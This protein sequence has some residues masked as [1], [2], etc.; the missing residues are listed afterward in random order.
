MRSHSVKQLMKYKSLKFATRKVKFI[1]NRC[2]TGY[3]ESSMLNITQ[4]L[5]GG[6]SCNAGFTYHEFLGI[7][8]C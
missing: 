5:F 1:Y 3:N 2:K 6:I 4:E 8:F 7:N